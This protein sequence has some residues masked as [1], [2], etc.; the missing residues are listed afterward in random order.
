MELH[1]MGL[2]LRELIWDE[3]SIREV[4]EILARTFNVESMCQPA[5]ASLSA[6]DAHF[7]SHLFTL[8]FVF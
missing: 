6:R 8:L 1:Q 2:L 3:I 7:T 4:K 5:L